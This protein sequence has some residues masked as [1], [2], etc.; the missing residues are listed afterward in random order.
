MHC[1]LQSH[2]TSRLQSFVLFLLSGSPTPECGL[3]PDPRCLATSS[4]VP[5]P[6]E[7]LVRAR[8]ETNVR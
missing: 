2:R 8:R 7:P 5:E 1:L 3:N 6:G 4:S